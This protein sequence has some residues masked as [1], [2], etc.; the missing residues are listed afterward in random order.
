MSTPTEIG[1]LN[2]TLPKRTI[3]ALD[4]VVPQRRKSSFIAQAIEEKLERERWER[5]FTAVQQLPP[6]LSHITN[7]VQWVEQLRREDEQ[8]LEGQE[9]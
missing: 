6:T 5:A 2:I 3:V 4:A 1:R 9:V 8:R 7:P